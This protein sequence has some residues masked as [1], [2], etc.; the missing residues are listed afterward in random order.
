L[1][2]L[3]EKSLCYNN[4]FIVINAWNEWGEGMYL[5]PDTG[6]EFNY[7]KAILNAKEIVG[8]MTDE[9]IKKDSYVINKRDDRIIYEYSK[10]RTLFKTYSNWI[11]KEINREDVFGHIFIKEGIDSIAIYG[12]GDM[13]R[14]LLSCLIRE[15]VKVKYAIDM[16]VARDRAGITIYRPEEELP[17]VDAIIITAYDR[18]EIKDSLEKKVESKIFYLQELL[19]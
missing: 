6:D 13:G 3:L 4:E 18:G 7:L 1:V 16:Y 19:E 2:K 5:E 14:N 15:N 8:R 10:F 9:E 12:M 17:E 11:Q